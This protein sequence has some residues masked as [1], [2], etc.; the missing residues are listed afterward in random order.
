[1][2]DRNGT[3]GALRSAIRLPDLTPESIPIVVERDGE[4]VTLAGYVMGKRCPIPVTI[5]QSAAYQQWQEARADSTL[6]AGEQNAAFLFYVKASLKA[7]VPGFKDAELD[8]IA[9]DDE[10]R[11]HILFELKVWTKPE[12]IAD[13][14]AAGEETSL[15]TTDGSSP[16]SAPSTTAPTSITG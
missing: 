4:E 16:V 5:A 9:A 1:M 15:P 8:V 2:A 6:S 10:L 3:S 7:V 14:E 12:D 13:P 11:S